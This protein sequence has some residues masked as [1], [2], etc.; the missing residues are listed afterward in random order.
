LTGAQISSVTAAEKLKKAKAV[1]NK[2]M[3]AMRPLSAPK[4]SASSDTLLALGKAETK[5]ITVKACGSKGTPS[6]IAAK[7]TNKTSTG[8]KNNFISTTGQ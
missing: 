1:V 3:R 4:R 5:T 2:M 8:C 6:W 7:P